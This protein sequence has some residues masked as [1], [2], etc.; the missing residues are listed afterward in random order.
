MH[1]DLQFVSLRL[2]DLHGVG[3]P[4]W[5]PAERGSL[6]QFSG[7]AEYSQTWRIVLFDHDNANTRTLEVPWA[8]IG[9]ITSDLVAFCTEELDVHMAPSTVD[10]WEQVSLSVSVV[11]RG[12]YHSNNQEVVG[13]FPHLLGGT[14]APLLLR[15]LDWV[16]SLAL[17]LNPGP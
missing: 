17:P 1:P 4:G 7:F 6:V 3:L 9:H 14:G 10:F 12:G 11:I 8:E 16:Q 5:G 13:V 2:L 15:L